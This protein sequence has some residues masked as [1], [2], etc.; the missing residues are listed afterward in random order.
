M[1]KPG[2][3]VWKMILHHLMKMNQTDAWRH[4]FILFVYTVC[5]ARVGPEYDVQDNVLNDSDSGN[6]AVVAVESM[7]L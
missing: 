3:P 6:V 1:N 7:P 2:F 5:K 4:Q